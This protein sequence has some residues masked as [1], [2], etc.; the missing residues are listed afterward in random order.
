MEQI[1]LLF[2]ILPHQLNHHAKTDALCHKVNG[3]WKKYS[4][5]EVVDLVD[6]VSLG[7]IAMGV[8]KDDK[9]AIISGNRPEWNMVDMGVL[10]L[11]AQDVPM[12]PTISAEDYAY[13]L[14]DANVIYVFVED[15][16]LLGKV[17]QVADRVPSL[18]KIFTFNEIAGQSHWSEVTNLADEANRQQLND[19]KAAVQPTDLATLIYTSGTT[20][21][22][23]GVM[24]SHNNLVSNVRAV[25]AELPIKPEHTVFSF[26]PLCH[27]FERMVL[28]TYMSIG[29]SVY[30]AENMDTIGDNLKEVKPHFFTSVPRLLE[31]V[32]DKIVAKG[33]ELTGVKK[34]LFFWALNLG[35]EYEMEGKS[36]W[37]HQQLNLANKLIFSKWRE[38]LGGRLI[39]IVTG[40]AALQPKLA[41][42][43][44][45]A[46]IKVREGYG[47]TET[48]PVT[49]FNRFEDGGCIFGS[50]GY[51]I[52]DVSVKLA[53]DGEILIKGPNVMMG[54]YNKPEATAEVI[55]ADGWFHSGDLGEWINGKFLKIIDRKK[56]LYKTSGGKYV[57]P[58]PLENKFKESP[59]I[60]Q[61]MVVGNDKRFVS[62]LIVPSMD[63][64]KAFCK[65]NG[66]EYETREE[67]L[68]HPDVMAAYQAVLDEFNP[69]FGNTEQIK[70][71]KLLDSEWTI[72]GGELTPTMKVK[73]KNILEKYAKE[74]AEIYGEH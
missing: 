72:A 13:I 45:A 30:Y 15:E 40:A 21:T 57:A 61:I 55:D 37:Y 6:K 51:P 38:A 62:A 59:L 46:Q 31:K 32:Y 14:N 35:L 71:F 7:L 42:V 66:I 8:K 4:T 16:E 19:M 12:Y 11:G 9:I 2:D 53:E 20:G 18:K 34:K 26:L 63:S 23:K 50:I 29:A 68:S 74:V 48:S 60:E 44:S 65:D 67:L 5:K 70:K 49:S 3:T 73:R 54:Y 36:W 28:Y 24:L 69:A 33:H 10:Q 56:E 17:Q 52:T 43:F 22:P 58:Q 39:G 1:Q 25:L 41:K 47:L 27:S 64:L